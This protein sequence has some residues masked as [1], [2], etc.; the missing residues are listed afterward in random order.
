MPSA[1]IPNPIQPRSTRITIFWDHFRFA[2]RKSA[3]STANDLIGRLGGFNSRYHGGS[4]EQGP[5]VAEKKVIEC[6]YVVLK[7]LLGEHVGT[8]I[9][10]I[11][12]IQRVQLHSVA[13]EMS[14]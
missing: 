4:V 14:W 3:G 2:V 1:V 12:A 5:E 13:L 8:N 9:E 10:V 11:D 6:A 7:N